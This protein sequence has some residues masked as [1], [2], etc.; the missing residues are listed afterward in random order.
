M[1]E[2]GVQ[3]FLREDMPCAGLHCFS[4]STKE[5]YIKKKDEPSQRITTCLT[6][7]HESDVHNH[8]IKYQ[9]LSKLMRPQRFRVV[10]QC[11]RNK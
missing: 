2:N 4:V 7:V 11:L 6:S 5:K 3:V 10:P 1:Y 9:S 8:A